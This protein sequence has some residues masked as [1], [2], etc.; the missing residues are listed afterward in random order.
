MASVYGRVHI[1]VFHI[2]EIAI[3]CRFATSVAIKTVIQRST[4]LE[5]QIACYHSW[6]APEQI[7]SPFQ[8]VSLWN[9]GNDGM[10]NE[11]TVLISEFW[12]NAWKSNQLVNVMMLTFIQ[13]IQEVCY[14]QG[15]LQ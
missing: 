5:H 7:T 10:R 2:K 15:I 8:T 12:E 9:G 1:I 4:G 11:S 14:S 13:L 6:D 3:E